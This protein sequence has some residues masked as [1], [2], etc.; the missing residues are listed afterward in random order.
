MYPRDDLLKSIE[1]RVLPG[2]RQP[3]LSYLL[4]SQ[5]NVFIIQASK[6]QST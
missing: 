1:Y 5:L 2:L 3:K 6:G 4:K